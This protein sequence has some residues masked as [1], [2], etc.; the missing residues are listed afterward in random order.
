MWA[1]QSVLAPNDCGM[2]ACRS[3]RPAGLGSLDRSPA[4]RSQMG[5]GIRDG[6]Q[7]IA[8]IEVFFARK[9]KTGTSRSP[10]RFRYTATSEV[11]SMRRGRI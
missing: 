11:R 10:G 6:L 2:D 9:E 8:S 1:Q 7:R 5:D 4:E 3:S